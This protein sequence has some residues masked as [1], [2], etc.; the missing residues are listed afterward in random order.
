MYKKEADSNAFVK[1]MDFLAAG[2][3]AVDPGRAGP[4]APSL[5]DGEKIALLPTVRAM[6]KGPRFIGRVDLHADDGNRVNLIRSFMLF[7]SACLWFVDLEQL[8]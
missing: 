2:I 5:R 8:G 6:A 4:V 3:E 7:V 1:D